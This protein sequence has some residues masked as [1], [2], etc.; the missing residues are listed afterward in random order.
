[1]RVIS[2]ILVF[3]LAI[4]VQ[5]FDLSAARAAEK[6][7]WMVRVRN[8]VVVPDEDSTITAIGGEATLGNAVVPEFDITYFFT[9]HWAAEL[10]AAVT[11]HNVRGENTALGSLD[12]GDVLLLPPTLTLQ[13]HF[14]P[15]Q[16]YRPYIGAGVN[17]TFFLDEDAGASINS[18]DYDNAFG[19]ALQAGVDISL[20]PFGFNEHWALNFDVKKIFLNT[21]VSIN[22][23]AV[24]ADVDIDP[25]IIGVGLAYRF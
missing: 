7:P 24:T 21:D 18:I 10:I 9:E 12:L 22:G 1:M 5:L 14:F 2:G 6:S 13:Y 23:G 19:A 8:L 4:A 15:E 16:N 17:Y 25:W 11:P 20:E 3:T